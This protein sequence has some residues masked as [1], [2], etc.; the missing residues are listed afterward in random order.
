[1]ESAQ[2]G[3]FGVKTKL[4]TLHEK[5]KPDIAEILGIRKKGG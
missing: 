3:E 2:F 4:Y 5:G 1:M